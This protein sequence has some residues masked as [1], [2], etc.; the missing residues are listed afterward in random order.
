MSTPDR[1]RIAVFGAGSIGCH[2]GG[3]LAA[4]AD[5]TLIGR[6]AAMAAIDRHGL[7][8]TGPVGTHRPTG[9]PA[10]ATDPAAAAGADFVL[11]TVKSTD[12]V[13][14]AR[15]L[16]GHLDAASVVVSFQNGLHNPR[17]LRAELPGHRVLAGMVP[18]NVVRTGPAAFHQGS[19]G[20]VMLEDAPQAA[21][22]ATA[23][24]AAGLRLELRSDMPAVQA[25]K[26]LMNL[27]N[28]INALSDLPLREQ[29]GQRPYRACLARCQ[30]EALAAFRAGGIRPAQL[31]PVPATR[32]PY[33]LRLPDA[34][35][36]RLAAASLRIDAQAR[37]S[38][39][40]D[41]QRGRPTEVD[42]LQGEVVA[43]AERHG[44]TAPANARLAALVRAAEQAGPGAAR[45]W[46]GP[47]L[48]A[49]L[50][51]ED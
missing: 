10:L 42:S 16:A 15:E 26:L 33:L 40:E 19:G 48:L 43:L 44:L 13:A 38:M 9:G 12:T 20:R 35:F 36:R 5:V 45:R 37:S 24:G 17:L 46:S 18:Y 34:L 21:A 4:V 2:L 47:E 23:A 22:L 8:L 41:L 39:W 6:P 49:E 50:T 31:G 30:R 14:A 32:T 3:L 7:T 29:L 51:R 27:N 28:A 1:L 25:A 11:V